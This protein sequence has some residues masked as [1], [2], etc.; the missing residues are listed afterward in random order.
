[1][2]VMIGFS[3]MPDSAWPDGSEKL[4]KGELSQQFQLWSVF[5]NNL[6]SKLMKKG[7]HGNEEQT[8][9]ELSYIGQSR[10]LNS[11]IQIIEK[12]LKAHFRKGVSEA[13]DISSSKSK[14]KAQ[15]LKIIENL[16]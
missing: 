8:F 15:L 2:A 4:E 1:M 7:T 5:A 14:F 9:E 3:K 11:Q 6:N 10:T 16:E 12:G 13:K